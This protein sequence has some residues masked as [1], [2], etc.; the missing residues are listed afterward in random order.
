VGHEDK[1]SGL[2]GFAGRFGVDDG[3]PVEVSAEYGIRNIGTEADTRLSRNASGRRS[4]AIAGLPVHPTGVG[5]VQQNC[6]PA[7]VLAA[8][9]YVVIWADWPG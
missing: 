5:C 1:S 3:T 6:S 2:I 9:V 7:V 8:F 4:A